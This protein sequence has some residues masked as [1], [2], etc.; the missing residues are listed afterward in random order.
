MPRRSAALVPDVVLS[1]RQME[2]IRQSQSCLDPARRIP[3]LPHSSETASQSSSTSQEFHLDTSAMM[4]LGQHFDLVMEHLRVQMSQLE[5]QIAQS[6]LAQC[7]EATL[8][9]L[10]A[11]EEIKRLEGCMTRMDELDNYFDEISSLHG[12][13]KGNRQRITLLAQQL[14]KMPGT[15][16]GDK[17]KGKPKDSKHGSSSVAKHSSCTAGDGA[18]SGLNRGSLTAN[19]GSASVSK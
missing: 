2:I 13:I 3:P 5:K 15:G 1:E 9:M 14:E 11:D 19:N 16:S 18:S 10:D 7:D 6:T 17:R 8:A 4:Q 12:I